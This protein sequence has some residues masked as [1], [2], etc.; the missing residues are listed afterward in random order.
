VFLL[1]ESLAI[2]SA[3]GMRPLRERIVLRRERVEASAKS[4]GRMGRGGWSIGA[5]RED[6]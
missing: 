4:R 6:W 5:L 2:S 3:R 1:D